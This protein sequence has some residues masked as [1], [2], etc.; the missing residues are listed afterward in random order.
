MRKKAFLSVVAGLLMILIVHQAI[1]AISF[2]S[3]NIGR[4]KQGV[5]DILAQTETVPSVNR[6]YWYGDNFYRYYYWTNPWHLGVKDFKDSTGT[7][8]DYMIANS[9]QREYNEGTVLVAQ[10]LDNEMNT[11]HRYFRFAPPDI[12]V[13]GLRLD[14]PMLPG[15]FVA[16]DSIDHYGGG[17]AEMMIRSKVNTWIG[18]TIDAK[19]LAFSQIHH[20]QYVIYDRTYTNT[21]LTQYRTTPTLTDTLH[22]VYFLRGFRGSET[23]R[24]QYGSRYG[25]YPG[26]TLRI[27][28][29]YPA[30][31]T[32]SWDRLGTR[33]RI[34]APT[35]YTRVP[36]FFGGSRRFVHFG[37]AA[38][39][40]DSTASITDDAVHQP[41]NHGYTH[42]ESPYLR[43]NAT[44]TSPEEKE[45]LYLAM[46]EGFNGI[47]DH[48]VEDLLGP[49][50]AG[51]LPFPGHHEIR[52]HDYCETIGAQ[53]VQD[54]PMYMYG[55]V[56]FWGAGPWTLAPGEDFRIVFSEVFGG[57]GLTQAQE[58]NKAWQANTLT[59]GDYSYSDYPAGDT[60]DNVL[61]PEFHVS[62]PALWQTPE[63]NAR[64]RPDSVNWAKDNWMHTGTD[65][66]F[67]NAY[68]GQWAVRNDYD[69]PLAPP[70]PSIEI[71]SMPDKI[72]VYWGSDLPS[73]PGAPFESEDAPG[74]AGYRV[75][76]SE[77]LDHDMELI[78]DIPGSGTYSYD[79]TE[80]Q[81][82]LAYYY[83]V[84]AY[85][86]GT[87]NGADVYNTN[88]V[89]ESGKLIN[90]TTLGAHLTRRPTASVDSFR[91]VPNPFHI[92][93][94]D[95]QFGTGEPNKIMFL[96][97]PPVCT[98]RIF[99]ESGDLVKTIEHTNLSGDESWG[100][101]ARE[102][103]VTESGQYIVSGVY[104][105]HIETPEGESA[106]QKFVIVR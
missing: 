81:R 47:A 89:L 23:S 101:L 84:T 98:I 54:L 103:S 82:G 19:T 44:A 92:G 73:S 17:N 85:D 7:I 64:W 11:V 70:A 22:D 48:P 26:D 95:L 31:G 27:T 60:P 87:S 63:D 18:L 99:S 12:F 50:E 83:A 77:A 46:S 58:V 105:A 53:M 66:L 88:E 86:D 91:V 100:V 71:Q 41:F 16:P 30:R 6:N 61:P 57:V 8:H 37:N 15:D 79:D 80:P 4:Y 74:F 51:I 69:V 102:H 10:Y 42:T 28:Y 94:F 39:H 96:D 40:I 72:V 93:A 75:Y 45:W 49:N 33:D 78:A 59:W 21:G 29:N 62:P 3:V 5:A 36:D 104:I 13:D 2:K 97:L 34:W 24:N 90:R 56:H 106:Y 43:N 20:D 55:I 9:P 1:D 67:K 76:R 52:L 38:L 32:T 35:G 25:E 68:A 14:D 65:S